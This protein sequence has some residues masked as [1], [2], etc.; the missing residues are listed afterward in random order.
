MNQEIRDFLD[1]LLRTKNPEY[2]FN[3]IL[4]N[5][6]YKMTDAIVETDGAK[7]F[8]EYYP[9]YVS[10]SDSLYKAFKKGMHTPRELYRELCETLVYELQKEHSIFDTFK[11]IAVLDVL[12]DE[13]K[14]TH[15]NKYGKIV[16]IVPKYLAVVR[17]DSKNAKNIRFAKK[18]Y[19]LYYLFLS[20]YGDTSIWDMY[21]YDDFY[22]FKM[23]RDLHDFTLA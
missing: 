21:Y 7:D 10:N 1:L 5:I 12:N 19:S 11:I 16:R 14:L 17:R 23:A 9:I 8:E 2:F 3:E 13:D 20:S 6:I 18:I 22:F 4:W 15:L